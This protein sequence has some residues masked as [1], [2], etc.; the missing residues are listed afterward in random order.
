MQ[1]KWT[2]LIHTKGKVRC[3][4][5]SSRTT[6]PYTVL[7]GP[8]VKQEIEARRLRDEQIEVIR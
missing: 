3:H 5:V 1:F 2:H 8:K 7:C 6:R 4:I